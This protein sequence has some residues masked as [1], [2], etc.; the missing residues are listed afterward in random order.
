MLKII[1]YMGLKDKP[2]RI[3]IYPVSKQASYEARYGPPQLL[4]V[5]SFLFIFTI[6]RKEIYYY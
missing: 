3:W 5:S 1:I 6:L 4:Y 2:A